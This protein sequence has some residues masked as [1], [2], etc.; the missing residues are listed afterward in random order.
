[1]SDYG[2]V[3]AAFEFTAGAV[4]RVLDSSDQ[5]RIDSLMFGAGA[6][7]AAFEEAERARQETARAQELAARQVEAT[8]RRANEMVRENTAQSISAVRSSTVDAM[9]FSAGA[10]QAAMDEV[11]ETR[12]R[13]LGTVIDFSNEAIEYVTNSTRSEASQ[14]FDKLVK[15]A[16][17]SVGAIAL[18][19]LLPRFFK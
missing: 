19:Q 16:G 3:D 10:F 7:Q 5:A 2:A 15:V 12:D 6:M 14:S 9:Q 1:M 11:S 8:Q 13:S 17:Y 4:G 18:L